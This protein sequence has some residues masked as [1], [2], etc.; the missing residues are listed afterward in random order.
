[1]VHPRQNKTKAKAAAGQMA[2]GAMLS[3]HSPETV[4]ILGAAGFD[5]VTFDLEHEAFDE[6]ALVHSIRAAEAFDLTPIVR[7][8]ND[9]DLILR[10]LDAGA[11]GVHVPRINTR[12]EAQAV[13]EASRFHPQGK[14]TFYAVG[15]SG[16]YGLGQTEEQYA[17]RSNDE[18]L[19]ILQVEEEE[20]VGMPDRAVVW[21]VVDRTLGRVAQA[22]LWGSMVAWL[23]SDVTAQLSRY[24]AMGVRLVT[25]S[26]REMLV[27]GCRYFL[28]Q[29]AHTG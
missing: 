21:E 11:Q 14:R 12:E 13:V 9:P 18:T 23:D 26:P 16:N 5:F 17:E 25:A 4:E 2:L 10:L 15:R 1:M 20:G 3:Y 6:L 29:A 7:V 27:H 8:P 28:D 24:R 22:G 19:V